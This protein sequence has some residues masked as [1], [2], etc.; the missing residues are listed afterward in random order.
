MSKMHTTNNLVVCIL[1]WKK[2]VIIISY[3]SIYTKERYFRTFL[4]RRLNP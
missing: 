2:I 1:L 3:L 4:E